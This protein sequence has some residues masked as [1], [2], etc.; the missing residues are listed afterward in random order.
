M[1]TSAPLPGLFD[2]FYSVFTRASTSQ[3]SKTWC[4]EGD[5]S[6]WFSKT[7]WSLAQ[8]LLWRT[9]Q[10]N[11]KE[12]S[13]WLPDYFCNASLWPSRKLGANIFFYPVGSDMQ[14]NYAACRQ[15]VET[16]KPDIFVL[17]HYF[18]KP[19]PSAPARDF[20]LRFGAWLVEDAAHVLRPTSGIGENGDFVVYSPHKLLAV[21]DGAML[22]VRGDGPSNLTENLFESLGDPERWA[23]QLSIDFRKTSD[24]EL[25]SAAKLSV[26]WLVKRLLQ[27]LITFSLT[28]NTTF[29]E[30]SEEILPD[31]NNFTDPKMS[32]LAARLLYR[33]VPS[34]SNVAR[35]RQRNILMLDSMLG[36][37]N[38]L[39]ESGSLT[40]FLRP[41]DREWTPYLATFKGNE[42]DIAEVF[43][44]L[45]EKGLPCSVWPDLPP[46]I[47]ASKDDHQA[48]W[49]LR[50]S[51][52]FIPIHQSLRPSILLKSGVGR[53]FAQRFHG[54]PPASIVWE[55]MSREEWHRFLLTAG[56]SSLMQTWAY[57]DAKSESEGWKVRRGE[58]SI[59]G[60]TEAVV[61]V[62]EKRLYGITINRINR[63]PIF[64]NGC[65]KEH[66]FSVIKALRDELSG[67][68]KRK[69]L[70]FAPEFFLNGENTAFFAETGFF[71]FS[72]RVW[73]SSWVDLSLDAEQLRKNLHSKWRNVLKVSER[74]GLELQIDSDLESFEWLANQ[75]NEMMRSR[76]VADVPISLYKSLQKNIKIDNQQLLTFRAIKDGRV[77]AGVCIAQHGSAATY[78]LGWNGEEGR[79]LK[80]NQFLLWN[81][82]L[83][84]K[85]EKFKWFDLGGIDSDGTPGI[86]DFK[87]GINGQRYSLIGEY[88]K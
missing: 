26:L 45:R 87:L 84:L 83:H 34:I 11:K 4:G 73:E 57:G 82:I 13:L 24:I 12:V 14:P 36:E 38:G 5:V 2:V 15:M 79:S 72:P 85:N 44:D 61:Q 8:I 60:V 62:L 10:Q 27:K 71:Q 22:V 56:R 69:I 77:T 6:G 33:M 18:G 64:I 1:Y 86:A 17:V 20:C 55:R 40:P 52:L 46:E 30:G 7:A 16:N 67:I 47:L 50:H 9:K 25:I 51:M 19:I 3:L 28:R 70:S 32:G 37:R 63:G 31:L 66:E 75:C 43:C 88:W 59:N 65:D 81:V 21:P 29:V 35:R 23:Y 42:D 48:A 49:K 80:A 53:Q 74:Q 76:G 39:K 58:I 41:V 78:L 68:G 54:I